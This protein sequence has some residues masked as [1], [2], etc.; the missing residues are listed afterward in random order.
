MIK[1]LPPGLVE[2]ETGNV[3]QDSAIG[4]E[5]LDI[6]GGKVRHPVCP[7]QCVE[8]LERWSFSARIGHGVEK[9]AGAFSSRETN[10][11]GSSLIRA[12]VRHHDIARLK[13]TR[14]GRCRYAS[15]RNSYTIRIW[16]SG[17]GFPVSIHNESCASNY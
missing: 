3:R 12:K 13:G 8:S 1:C 2:E 16:I 5:H 4:Y 17:D 14:S 10:K 15:G 7:S 9:R 6:A 11:G